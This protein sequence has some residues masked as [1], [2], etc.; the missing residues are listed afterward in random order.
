MTAL[1]AF[2]GRYKVV[3][4]IGQGGMGVL[5]LAFD[6]MLERQV[7]IKLLRDDNEELRQR[8]AREARSV[9]RLR[10]PHIVTIFDVGEQDGNPFIAMEYL[11]GQTLAEVIRGAAPI[12]VPK[13][14][15]LIDELC[16]GLG[17]AHK[18]G[19]VHRDVKPA[20]VM[21]DQDGVVK[22]LDFGIA[23][24]AESG[25]TQ[26]GML[27]GTL[28]YMSPEQVAGQVVDGRSDIFAVGAVLYELLAYTQAFPGGLH[29]GIL[30]KILHV[31]PQPLQEVCLGLDAEVIG[32]VNCAMQKDPANRYQDLQA[33]R[34]D[35]Q[36]VRH[37]LE[38]EL[39]G[40]VIVTAEDARETAE[41]VLPVPTPRLPLTPR[42]VSDRDGLA[43]RRAT[44]IA[45]HM[46]EARR[47]LQSGDFDG[48]V[49][50][51][52]QALLLNAEEPDA[53]R[54]LEQVRQ[55]VDERQAKEW[56]ARAADL[57][58]Q[59]QHT[60][61][62]GYADQALGLIPGSAEALALRSAIEESLTRRNEARQRLDAAHAALARARDLFDRQA[63][64]QA[65]RAAEA[66][67]ALSPDLTG[68]AALRTRALDTLER[69]RQDDQQR[70]VAD[71]LALAQALSG[72][73][74]FD[75][76]IAVLESCGLDDEPI[77]TTLA[78]LRSRRAQRAARLE[79]EQREREG[80]DREVAGA[81]ARANAETSHEAAL[82]VLQRALEIDSTRRDVSEMI[83]SRRAALTAE[84]DEAKRAA[85]RQERIAAA[86]ATAKTAPTHDAAIAVLREAVAIDPNHLDARQALAERVEA[87]E[88]ELEAAAQRAA[89]EQARQAREREERA[90]AALA[91]AAATPAH[92]AAVAILQRACTVDPEHDG[93]REA[94]DAR[95]QAL[96]L[97]QE[98]HRRARERAERIA[99]AI[100]SAA[101]TASHDKA[102]AALREAL[103]LDPSNAEVRSLLESRETALEQQRAQ[104]RREAEQKAKVAAAIKQAKGA[105]SH[106]AAI[107]LLTEALTID[108]SNREARTLLESR[109]R[110]LDAERAE[111]QRAQELEAARKSIAA[112]IAARDLDGAEAGLGE[113]ERRHGARAFKA[114]R[115]ELRDARQAGTAASDQ[116]PGR[117]VARGRAFSPAGIVAVAAVALVLV[118]GG[119]FLTHRTAPA[120]PTTQEG[121][122]PSP[123]P[124]A[125][126]ASASP[127]ETV[128]AQP[129]GRGAA[130]TSEPAS[131]AP[132]ATAP[133]AA[134]PPDPSAALERKSNASVQVAR[135]HLARKDVRQA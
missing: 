33:M 26:A 58:H 128:P 15:Q 132:A 21:I 9:A 55:A 38:Q 113:A 64:E 131:D 109:Q 94:L 98:Q 57:L 43:R 91:E 6:P 11:H 80:R 93:L 71:L 48:A 22:V 124:S 117:P 39:S 133:P 12:D 79:E 27:I 68:A 5:F 78:D 2:I 122:S 116:P 77:V 110:A 34:R 130:A 62:R 49:V 36:R 59:G 85:Q 65:A 100:A 69:Q 103:A 83:E 50:A 16:D 23:R 32:I 119:Y 42:A 84:R 92:D 1:P 70:R 31:Q 107:A 10:H 56:L 46:E 111:A 41:I 90:A 53:L 81:I 104:E 125:P 129:A 127:V 96:A 13:K 88:R 66:A 35:L 4:R 121:K 61:A 86:L 45:A 24:I 18:A 126:A 60:E 135:Q 29:S 72:K 63:F 114:L 44:Q 30:N 17:Y 105:K 108:G 7:A 14:L 134:A 19:I 115:R 51:A 97:E 76:A 112:M 74:R 99:A 102:I 73:E 123:V 54:I 75:E 3:S 47:A 37:R 67:L 20:N 40:T 89:E 52:E 95:R 87:R 28:N 118:G 25:M 101:G 8:F 106:D 120:V 82:A